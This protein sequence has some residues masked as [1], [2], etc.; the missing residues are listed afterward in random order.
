VEL[1]SATKVL[2]LC[3]SVFGLAALCIGCVFLRTSQPK[4]AFGIIRSKTGY[5]GGTYSQQQ[6]GMQ[7][8]FRTATQI[9]TAPSYSFEVEVEGLPEKARCSLNTDAA[10]AFEVGQR[11][12]V[13][14]IVR[15]MKPIWSRIFVTRMEAAP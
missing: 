14:Y 13:E 12:R 4:T 5:G 2:L 15:G 7:R 6:V 1:P 11:V 3:A 8:G 10:T 9:P